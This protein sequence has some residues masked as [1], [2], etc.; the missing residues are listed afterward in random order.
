[1][2]LVVAVRVRVV[3]VYSEH[4]LRPS[5]EETTQKGF[6]TFA[7][8]PRPESVCVRVRVRVVAVCSVLPGV[9]L[10]GVLVT[11]KTQSKVVA[12]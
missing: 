4:F 12:E 2:V 8:K 6:R 7:W 9:R 11:F 5:E 1:M 3:A 10:R